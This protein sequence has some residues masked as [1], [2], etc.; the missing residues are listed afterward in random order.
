MVTVLIAIALSAVS[1]GL[2]YGAITTLQGQ[3]GGRPGWI[4]FA[5]AVV[6]IV[7]KERLYRWAVAV[8]R[9][10]KSPAVIANAWH[11][12]SDA[13]SS[14]PAALA[15]AGAAV[16]PRLSFLD[17]VGA[18][19]VS[20]FILHA[21]WRIGWPGLKQLADTGASEKHRRQIRTIAL[22]TGGVL[23]VHA[24]R[25]RYIG[26]GMQVDLHVQVDPDMTVREGH[27][28]AGM[29]KHRL[30]DEGPDLLDVVV[31]LEPCKRKNPSA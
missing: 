20:L 2:I 8:G 17:P 26:P 6:S 27:A 3:H 21:A 25:T 31:H 15:V 10:I 13:L 5:A 7:T 9:T 29:V 28:I 18:V 11:H 4:A 24:V 22:A 16:A 14:V 23:E 1:V 30:L 12:R 19:L